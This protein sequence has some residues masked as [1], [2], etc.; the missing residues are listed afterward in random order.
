MNKI[1]EKYR[2]RPAYCLLKLHFGF[3]KTVFLCFIAFIAPTSLL[4]DLLSP[5]P[6]VSNEELPVFNGLGENRTEF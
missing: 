1:D 5:K 4:E 2:L 3:K 6:L